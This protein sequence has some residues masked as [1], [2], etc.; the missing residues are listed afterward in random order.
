M[1]RSA[2]S[3]KLQLPRRAYDP[4]ICKTCQELGLDHPKA[5][6]VEY[7]DCEEHYLKRLN[8]MGLSIEIKPMRKSRVRFLQH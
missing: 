7:S 3:Q 6:R 2:I 8:K 4:Q 1:V 5:A